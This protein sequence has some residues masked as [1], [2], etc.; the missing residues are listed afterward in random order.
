MPRGGQKAVFRQWLLQP[1]KDQ[2]DPL[3][4]QEIDES[5]ADALLDDPVS[6]EERTFIL[7]GSGPDDTETFRVVGSGRSNRM[8]FWEILY[9]EA[10][11]SVQ[12]D[13]TELK[14]LLLRAM[15]YEDVYEGGHQT[16]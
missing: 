2:L 7:A 13:R 5:T 3:D 8:A 11:D 10:V 9:E 15:S 14:E 1:A 4:C 6:I 16:H 12:M